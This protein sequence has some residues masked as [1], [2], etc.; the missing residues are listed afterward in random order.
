MVGRAQ[1]AS[2]FS[3]GTGLVRRLRVN[4]SFRMHMT[5]YPNLFCDTIPDFWQVFYDGF[6]QH[7]WDG[8]SYMID[9]EFWGLIA[10]R[11]KA[12]GLDCGESPTGTQ[13]PACQTRNT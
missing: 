8:G 2:V 3:S 13:L 4:Y 10:K 12:N 6:E 11:G 9:P 5:P 1:C 7:G